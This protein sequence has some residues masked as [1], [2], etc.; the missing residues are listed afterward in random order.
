MTTSMIILII[1]GIGAGLLGYFLSTQLYLGK[2]RRLL[3]KAELESEKLKKDMLF[4]A[5]EENMRLQEKFNQRVIEKEKH[6]AIKENQIRKKFTDAENR[7]RSKE[8]AVKNQLR[9]NKENQK[10]LESKAQIIDQKAAFYKKELIA[11]ESA[12]KKHLEKL[13]QVS[14]LSVEEIERELTEQLKLDAQNEAEK[15]Y[16]E[17]IEEAKLSVEKEAQK[18]IISSIQRIGV[19]ESIEKSVTLFHLESDQIKGRII[20]R[21]GRNIRAIEEITG[22]DLVIDDTPETILLSCFDPVRREIARES[23]NRLV[24]DGRIHPA[25][26]EDVV[27]K[28]TKNIENQIIE[29]GKKT[30]ID[31]NIHGIHPE[32]IRII[33]RMRFRTS[34]GQNLLHHSKEV[35]R[36]CGIMAAELGLNVKQAKRGGLLHDIGKVPE[37]ESELSHALLGMKWAEKYGESEVVCNAI[38]AHHDEIEMTNSISPIIQVCD[39]ISG[40]RPGARSQLKENYLQRLKDLEDMCYAYEGVTKAYAIHAGREL[41]VFVES[42][43]VDD[44]KTQQLSLSLSRKIQSEMTYPGHIKVTVIRETRSVNTAK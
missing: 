15:Y 26:I 31:L 13:I 21:E 4:Q 36:L 14:S 7:I 1:T 44:Q 17:A 34:Y 30:I 28:V 3:A 41:R 32:L 43:E 24:N 29:Y 5:K 38:G 20:G 10:R 16:S 8:A 25:R 39:A 37:A 19:E 9:Q 42:G 33:G 27:K 35:S 23:L 11:I 2:R 40:A 6:L 22:V 18:I 12:K